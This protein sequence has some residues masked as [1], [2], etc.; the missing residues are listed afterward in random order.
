MGAISLKIDVK[1]AFDTIN[2]KFLIHVLKCFGFNQ[3]FC[4][5][6]L[7]ILNS[8]KISININGKAV[9][10]FSC[11]R[12]VRQGD[13]LSPL[14]FCIAEE[15]LSRGLEA[16]V[17]EGSLTQI[18][19]SITLFIPSHCLYAD[20]ILIFC[21][22]SLTNVRNIMH[23]FERYGDY[24]GQLINSQK[25]KFYTGGIT[26][27]RIH[28][29]ASITEFNQGSLP[30]TYLGILLFK[31]KPKALHLRPIVD[32]IKHKL[33]AWKGRLLTII[34]RAQLINAANLLFPSVQMA[35]KL[36]SGGF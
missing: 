27:S 29:I 2:W 26:L 24:S 35:F 28:T 20:D 7:N 17:L 5:W 1:K 3:L 25:S 21:K 34:G 14:L 31:G 32:K 19:A 13:P 30:F 12:G 4:G 11:S 16:M 9:G 23:L 18:S 36:T 33:S 22:G 10:F 8:A 15:V 6:I